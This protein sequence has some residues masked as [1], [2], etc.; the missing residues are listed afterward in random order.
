MKFNTKI[1]VK[2]KPFYIAE[3]QNSK[4]AF[5]N[6]DFQKSWKHLET[7]HVIAQ[8]YPIE[9]TIVHW[10]M[11]QFGIKIK[12]RK[13]ILGQIPRLIFGGIKSFVGKIPT[14]NTG[15][16]NVPPLQPMEIP[17]NLKKIIAEN[18]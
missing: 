14:G 11:L 5:L 15:G 1:P 3:L 8:I 10:K 7:A 4:I 18:I 12:N 17:E 2:L 13:E 16:A 9:H 6:S